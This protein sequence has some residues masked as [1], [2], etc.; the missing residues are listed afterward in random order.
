[1]TRSRGGRTGTRSWPAA[2]RPAQPT[3]GP[4]LPRAGRPRLRRPGRTG[5][6]R[7][8]RSA[9]RTRVWQVQGRRSPGPVRPPAAP[10]PAAA[11]AAQR[12]RLLQRRGPGVQPGRRGL[13]RGAVERRRGVRPGDEA[14]ERPRRPGRRRRLRATARLPRLHVLGDA[15]AEA[16]RKGRYRSARV[17]DRRRHARHDAGH[18]PGDPDSRIDTVDTGDARR[19]A[20]RDAD[21]RVTGRSTSR[22]GTPRARCCRP[23]RC[24]RRPAPR[25]EIIVPGSRR[26]SARRRSSIPRPRSGRRRQPT[27]CGPTTTPRCSC[28]T[29]GAR[30]RPRHDLDRLPAQRPTRPGGISAPNGPRP[31]HRDLHPAVPACQ[32]AQ[33]TSLASVC[34]PQRRHAGSSPPTS[35]RPRPTAS[36]RVRNPA[37]THIVDADQRTVELP[38]LSRSGNRSPSRRPGSANVMPPGPYML[39]VNREVDGCLKPLEGGA[40]AR[41]GERPDH[42]DLGLPGAAL[43]DR[44]AQHRPRSGWAAPGPSSWPSRGWPRS[45]R[46]E[47]R[48]RPTATASRAARAA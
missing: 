16:R 35:P 34:R 46:R 37:V 26:P 27:G 45:V 40:G 41:L 14:L 42:P 1:M 43:A 9:T 36:S 29:R 23:A 19:R 5:T 12:A 28:P 4:E 31:E 11:P 21:D 3:T 8:P 32:G 47:E 48:S 15:A 20:R 22:A 18:V 13:Q 38:I 30:R 25:D 2:S 7:R 44:P 6:C 33:P 39:F 24:S 17:P 10:V